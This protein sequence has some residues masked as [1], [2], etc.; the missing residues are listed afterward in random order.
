M[1]GDR[2]DRTAFDVVS[3]READDSDYWLDRT[4]EE[5][6]NAM[7]FMRRVMY[8]RDR[9]SERLQRILEIAELK[10]G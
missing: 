10:E 8:G 2:I 7:E 3:L 5:R 1:T 6:L 4:P 9:V